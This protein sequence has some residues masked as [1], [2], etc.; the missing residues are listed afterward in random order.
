[1]NLQ[2][3]RGT[4]DLLPEVQAKHNIIRDTARLISARFGFQEISTPIF[5]FSD[6]FKRTLGPASDIVN[7]EMYTFLD[8][9]GEELTLRPEGTAGVARCFISEGLS[10]RTPLKLFYDGPMFRYERPQKGRQRQFHQFGAELLGVAT[11][12]ADVECLTL[13]SEILRSLGV[14]EQST[15]EINS[16][17]DTASRALF[18]E[19]LVEFLKSHR[20]KLSPDSQKRMELNPLR[21]LDSK[22]PGDQDILKSAPQIADFYNA[23]ST[24]FFTTLRQML[25][26]LGITYVINP[27]LVRGLDYYAHSVFEFKSTALGAQDAILSGGRYDQLIQTMGGPST[28]GVGLAAGIERLVMLTSLEPAPSRPIALI[29]V[30]SS[31]ESSAMSLCYDLRRQGFTCE[32]AFSGN[33]S[34]RMKRA[35]SQQC[36]AAVIIGPDEWARGEVILK[37]LDSGEQKLVRKENLATT[38]DGLRPRRVED[39]PQV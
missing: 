31:S 1:M 38:L 14:L 18:S 21:T 29:P 5:E 32:M 11:P 34:K 23:S 27:R 12:L 7:K 26:D 8:R 39:I 35:T 28:P 6:V 17:G 19:S 4:H 2:S 16:L 3:V 36:W 25:D 33:L 22:D 15:L 20:A 37:V 9:N 13:A 30:H 24:E 10:Q